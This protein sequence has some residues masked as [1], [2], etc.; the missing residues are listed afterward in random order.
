M[1]WTLV[2]LMMH[3]RLMTVT[4]ACAEVD[5]LA[6]RNGCFIEYLSTLPTEAISQAFQSP[7]STRSLPQ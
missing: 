5:R 7:A 1:A 2:N 3:V 6:H 4:L